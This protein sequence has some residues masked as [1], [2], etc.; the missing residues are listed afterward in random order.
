MPEKTGNYLMTQLQKTNQI[1][2][3]GKGLMIGIELP[4]PVAELRK[5]L[6]FEYNISPVFQDRT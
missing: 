3:R 5:K 6:L 4:F 2:V 1:E